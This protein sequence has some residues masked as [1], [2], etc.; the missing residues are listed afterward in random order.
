MAKKLTR[1][2]PG[3]KVLVRSDL[4]VQSYNGL[5]ATNDMT[6]YKGKVLTVLDVVN[7]G[8]W[9]RCVE[10]YL[11]TNAGNKGYVFKWSDEMVL[12]VSSGRR[13]D[14]AIEHY[15]ERSEAFFDLI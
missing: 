15:V 10:A 2:K 9:F 1:Y 11:L 3:D 14:G 4:K 6:S 12:P 8:M 5:S 7:D 13:Y